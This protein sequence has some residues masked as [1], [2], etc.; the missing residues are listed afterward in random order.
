MSWEDS[1]YT[2]QG[3]ISEAWSVANTDDFQWGIEELKDL[4]QRWKDAG[5]AGPDDDS[6]LWDEFSSAKSHFHERRIAAREAREAQRNDNANAKER[7]ISEIRSLS[8]ST[9]W[10]NTHER[11]KRLREEFYEIGSAGRDENQRLKSELKDA[12][13][14][15]YENRANHFARLEQERND[16]RHE[17]ER[18]ISRAES[19][20]RSTD[21]QAT[22]ETLKELRKE[23]GEIGSAGKEE[24]QRLRA[25]FNEVCN[26]FYS[27]WNA[28]REK[29]NRE[30]EEAASAK[31]RLISRAESLAR[32]TEWKATHEAIQELRNEFRQLK[33]AG[34]KN[35]QLRDDFDAACQTFYIRRAEFFAKREAEWKAA[36]SRKENII[37]RAR[38]MLNPSNWDAARESM[39][40]LRHEW[41][42]A[43]YAGTPANDELKTEFNRIQNNFY[44]HFK[45]WQAANKSR[46]SQAERN[47]RDLERSMRKQLG[48]GKSR[49]EDGGG[50][51]RF[52]DYEEKSRDKDGLLIGNYSIG[53]AGYVHGT[54]NRYPDKKGHT[55]GHASGLIHKHDSHSSGKG[56]DHFVDGGKSPE[57][58]IIDEFLNPKK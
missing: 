3:L 50:K 57:G 45:A 26:S 34:G 52:A 32:S 6:D 49:F 56:T 4:Q 9:D 42:I 15:F 11:I 13:D 46:M 44:E 36:A 30:R 8:S 23:F 18:I 28:H 38:G 7:I 27:A 33:N 40:D 10:K 20:A 47:Q 29:I 37:S 12:A 48:G 2:K 31:E 39:K 55:T 25:E 14:E 51:S 41:D 58:K 21:W 1:K 35:Q 5:W 17:K 16:N 19:L 22:H 43:G 24:N 53:S 54:H